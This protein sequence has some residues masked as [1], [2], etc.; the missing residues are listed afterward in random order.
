MKRLI[1]LLTLL[2]TLASITQ[3]NEFH[4]GVDFYEKGN[5]QD[6]LEAFEGSLASGETAA[7]RHNLALTYFQLGQPAAAAWQIE[8]A[9]QLAPYN[10]EYQYKL[11]ALRTQLGFFDARPEWYQLAAQSLTFNQWILLAIV[12]FWLSLALYLF[13]ILGG[14]RRNLGLNTIQTLSLI[15]FAL[16]VPAIILQSSTHQRGIVIADEATALHAAPASAAPETGN[17]R[18]GERARVIDQHNDFLKIETEGQAS[19]WIA[20]DAFKRLFSEG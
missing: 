11:G 19:G 12:S 1:Y 7:T 9:V 6:A 15:L 5:Y 8:R 20:E 13:P 18:P 3:A 10:G 16:S 2:A 4:T 17:A 14:F